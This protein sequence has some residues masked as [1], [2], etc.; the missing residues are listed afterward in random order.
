M[1]TSIVAITVAA[2]GLVVGYFLPPLVDHLT[3]DSLEVSGDTT[4]AGQPRRSGDRSGA[5]AMGRPA[6][7]GLTA[8]VVAVALGAVVAR[9]ATMALLPA[10]TT[11]TILGITAGCVDLRCRRLPDAL[12]LP[13]AAI[14]AI[15]VTML[16][17]L[18]HDPHRLIRTAIG[19]V[20]VSTGL[21]ILAVVTGSLGLGDVKTSMWLSIL[22]GWQGTTTLVVAVTAPF[23]IQALASTILL[24]IGRVNRHAVLPFGP[25]IILAG[26][27]ALVVT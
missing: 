15:N 4:R 5:Y 21:L 11:T 17:A 6:A 19:T 13:G 2:S 26:L 8:T 10:A 18:D 24:C 20:A 27:A 16:A 9:L 25:A 1:D 12:V 22:C 3:H 14:C 7:R 23:I